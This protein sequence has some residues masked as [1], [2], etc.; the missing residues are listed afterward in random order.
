MSLPNLYLQIRP[1]DHWLLSGRPRNNGLTLCCIPDNSSR[2]PILWSGLETSCA[3][4]PATWR[5]PSESGGIVKGEW[6]GRSEASHGPPLQGGSA[7]TLFWFSI[8]RACYAVAPIH[9][10]GINCLR[11]RNNL[12]PSQPQ[13]ECIFLLIKRLFDEIRDYPNKA[14]N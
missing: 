7:P 13:R 1:I 8:R 4:N 11:N 5:T 6:C 10:V 12:F 3:S 2:S 14:R 9:F